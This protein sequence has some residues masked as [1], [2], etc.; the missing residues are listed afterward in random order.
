MS[1]WNGGRGTTVQDTHIQGYVAHRA[2]PYQ[3]GKKKLSRQHK[4]TQER[5]DSEKRRG[6]A[7]QNIKVWIDVDVCVRYVLN[8]LRICGCGTR[9]EYSRR[10]F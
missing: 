8:S 5:G 10:N 7:G 1:L 2:C 4:G 9:R 3:K 6:V